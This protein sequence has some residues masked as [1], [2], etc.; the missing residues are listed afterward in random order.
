MYLSFFSFSQDH[1]HSLLLVKEYSARMVCIVFSVLPI[2][3]GVSELEDSSYDVRQAQR[4]VGG[5]VSTLPAGVKFLFEGEKCPAGAQ[6]RHLISD[7]TGK[8]PPCSSH[9]LPAISQG[10]QAQADP[11]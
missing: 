9:L 11:L 8:R 7:K 5:Q 2:S 6:Q 3:R 4:G 10:N 1:D